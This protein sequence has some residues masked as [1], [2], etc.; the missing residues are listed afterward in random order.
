M[1]RAASVGGIMLSHIGWQDD[2]MMIATPKTKTDQTGESSYPKSIFAN[3][4]HPEI[5]PVLSVAVVL[6][7]RPFLPNNP[8]LFAGKDN[9]DRFSG[10]LS[11]TLKSL[12]EAD[13][14][15]LGASK[16]DIG[17]HSARKG[18]PSYVLSLPAGPSTVATYLRA[19]WSVGTTQDRYIF[20]G[21]GGDQLCGRA[22][23]GLSIHDT[24]FASLPPHFP[25]EVLTTVEWRIIFPGYEIFPQCFRQCLPFLLASV[26]FHVEFLRKSLPSTHPVFQSTLFSSGLMARLGDKAITGK[27]KCKSTGLTAC[28]VPQF[29]STA[30]E[31]AELKK[32]LGELRSTVVE[33]VPS[34][35]KDAILDNFSVNGI[36]PLTPSDLRQT[37]ER[38]VE[39]M[40]EMLDERL[41]TRGINGQTSREEENNPE[42]RFRTW[43]YG[44]RIH[45]VPEGWKFPRPSAKALFE[46]WQNGNVESQVQPLKHLT[47]FD[48]SRADWVEVSR[49]KGVFCRVQEIAVQMGLVEEDANF[50]TLGSRRLAE[51]FDEAF[52][53]LIS[54]VST[55]RKYAICLFVWAG[56]LVPSSHKNS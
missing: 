55:R 17:T 6:L 18:A 19:G 1:A 52:K 41:G 36:H 4:C 56:S 45:M 34:R 15:L 10:A 43:T 51:V 31:V 37:Q 49:A 44:G 48:V 42:R 26:V 2:H 22:V 46:L 32:Q 29:L 50:S 16:T 47:K 11:S 5:C 21:E 14:S 25:P 13:A 23:C 39:A 20:S 53:E 54:Q 38:M 35:V 30:V 24:D 9:E 40:K 27:G 28:G 8:A 7:C 3:P 33:E 12:S